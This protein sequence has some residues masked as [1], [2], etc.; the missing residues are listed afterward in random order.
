MRLIVN[1]LTG[2]ESLQQRDKLISRLG[3]GR[4]LHNATDAVGVVVNWVVVELFQ[5]R[6]AADHN[7]SHLG[8]LPSNQGT[9]THGKQRGNFFDAVEFIAETIQQVV[10]VRK[11]EDCLAQQ[12]VVVKVVIRQLE[13][14]V[15]T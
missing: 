12:G 9:R 2:T 3:L 6:L 11:W 5:P 13:D 4:C 7:L 1:K 10:T 15:L 14:C 8:V